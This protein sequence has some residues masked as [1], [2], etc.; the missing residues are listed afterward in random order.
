MEADTVRRLS[1]I[2]PLNLNGR[3]EVLTSETEITRS[4]VIDV[5]NKA[6]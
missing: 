3:R 5:L 4:N 1:D 6:L 2:E